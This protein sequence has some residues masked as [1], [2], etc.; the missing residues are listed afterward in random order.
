MSVIRIVSS[1]VAS[2]GATHVIARGIMDKEPLVLYAGIWM[3]AMLFL[4]ATFIGG[5]KSA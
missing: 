5:R 4:V 1:A 2:F 3:L